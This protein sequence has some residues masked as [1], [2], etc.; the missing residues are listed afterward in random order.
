M[1]PISPIDDKTFMEHADYDFKFAFTMISMTVTC[2][3]GKNMGDFATVGIEID[4]FWT[5]VQK[6]HMF[7]GRWRA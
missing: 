5:W 7:C 3:C 6:H 2:E 1:T 4:A